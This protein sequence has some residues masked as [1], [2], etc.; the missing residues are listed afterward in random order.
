MGA[1]NE[2]MEA[3]S[4]TIL[5]TWRH[6]TLPLALPSPRGPPRSV[7]ARR[8]FRVP[9]V[10]H[11]RSAQGNAQLPGRRRWQPRACLAAGATS[12]GLP[13]LGVPK[14]RTGNRHVGVPA[15]RLCSRRGDAAPGELPRLL[16]PPQLP[17]PTFS[18]TRPAGGFGILTISEPVSCQELP[19]AKP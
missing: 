3:L 10:V 14:T 19:L 13:R 5:G 12:W 4:A 9:R 17:L 11:V 1:A 15:Q 8:A 2:E 16:V 7:P 18:G 6:S